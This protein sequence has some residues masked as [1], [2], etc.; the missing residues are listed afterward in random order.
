MDDWGVTIE[1]FLIEVQL[2]LTMVDCQPIV[3]IFEILLKRSVACRRQQSL[4][5]FH[6]RFQRL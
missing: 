4:L 1:V 3:W 5:M 6:F 2:Q